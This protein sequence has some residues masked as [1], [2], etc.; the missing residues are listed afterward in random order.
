MNFLQ[1]KK[2]VWMSFG[3][4]TVFGVLYAY[5]VATIWKIPLFICVTLAYGLFMVVS[6]K[7]SKLKKK[8]R[9]AVGEVISMLAKA[10]LTIILI[11]FALGTLASFFS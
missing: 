6:R 7:Q 11:F 3:M 9:S 8:Q 4:V 5:L 2:A 10:L 1:S